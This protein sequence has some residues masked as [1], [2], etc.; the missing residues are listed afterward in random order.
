M[1][2]FSLKEGIIWNT[3]P[4]G[5]SAWAAAKAAPPGLRLS[6]PARLGQRRASVAQAALAWPQ[7]SGDIWKS[8]YEAE[9]YKFTTARL[10]WVES[11]ISCFE[12]FLGSPHVGRETPAAPSDSDL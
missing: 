10:S 4:S 7:A 1:E 5:S 11:D 6:P 2:L 12:G 9:K 8:L 3:F